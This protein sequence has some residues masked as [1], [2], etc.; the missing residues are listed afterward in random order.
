VQLGLVGQRVSDPV[1]L[2]LV[3][4]V[5]VDAVRLLDDDQLGVAPVVGRI[6]PVTTQSG[7]LRPLGLRLDLRQAF[8][9][10]QRLQATSAVIK[11]FGES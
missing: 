7:L 2:E 5:E 1:V 4:V 10:N 11:D 3:Q 6:V 9:V 8:P